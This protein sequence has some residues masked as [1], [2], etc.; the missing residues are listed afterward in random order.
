MYSSS[1]IEKYLAKRARIFR[2][3]EFVLS[4]YTLKRNTYMDVFVIDYTN[5][6][7]KDTANFFLGSCSA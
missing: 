7:V 3:A 1:Q 5:C 2:M 6:E 4:C